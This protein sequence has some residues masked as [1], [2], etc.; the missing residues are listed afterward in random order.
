[1]KRLFRVSYSNANRACLEYAQVDC[2]TDPSI[3]AG[4]AFGAFLLLIMMVG[5]VIH[6]RVSS[7]GPGYHAMD[8]SATGNDP[9]IHA[10]DALSDDAASVLYQGGDGDGSDESFRPTV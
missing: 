9:G 2:H 5:L 1:M 4:I 3:I 8:S 6:A 7:G 10:A